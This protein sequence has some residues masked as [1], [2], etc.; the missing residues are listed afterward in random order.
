MTIS[1]S[2]LRQI[3]V[4]MLGDN[5][6]KRKVVEK[7]LYVLEFGMEVVSIGFADIFRSQKNRVCVEL[8]ISAE[9]DSCERVRTDENGKEYKTTII[10]VLKLPRQIHLMKNMYTKK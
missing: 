3:S 6:R 2:Y 10:N 7:C 5:T 8:E 4:I 9:R 1:I